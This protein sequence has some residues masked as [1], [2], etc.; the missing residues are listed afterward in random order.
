MP[1]TLLVYPK[2]VMKSIESESQKGLTKAIMPKANDI[3]IG[4]ISKPDNLR[5]FVGQISGKNNEFRYAD[6]LGDA[7]HNNYMGYLER[8]WADHLVAVITPDIIW[9]TILCELTLL[10]AEQTET[11][12][13]LFTDSQEK[14]T[15]TV[16][17]GDPVVMPL[18]SLISEL[19]KLVPT[20]VNLF[21]PNFSTSNERSIFAGYAAFC[22]MVSPYYNYC[23]YACGIPRIDVRGTK[24]DYAH[25][26]DSWL[27]IYQLLSKIKGADFD[28]FKWATKI[29][30]LL[31]NIS[32]NLENGDFW[33][34]MF[35]LDECGSGSDVEVQGWWRDF[36]R[37]QPSVAYPD[38][39]S[40][41]VS[42]V[43]YKY[44][45]NDQDYIMKSGLF[46][47]NLEGEGILVPEFGR[48]VYE[49]IKNG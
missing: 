36:Y 34:K 3:K 39:F 35:Y 6:I 4:T 26:S 14:K 1:N 25:L 30:S 21:L 47:S 49:K 16:L 10:I 43:S 29:M 8:C 41:H 22:D 15:I 48:I 46:F 44:L 13:H 23:M 42:N 28:T 40:T 18:D 17:T 27:K 20:D 45:P 7:Y 12:R 32:N 5:V 24:E 38:N 2:S 33:Q 11:Y 37:K 31:P 9:Y 19:K